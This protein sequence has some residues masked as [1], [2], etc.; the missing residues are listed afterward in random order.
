MP[1]PG[2]SE[3]CSAAIINTNIN[4]GY[5]ELFEDEKYVPVI[6]NTAIILL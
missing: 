4:F 6:N 3:V 5:E 1:T 2:N